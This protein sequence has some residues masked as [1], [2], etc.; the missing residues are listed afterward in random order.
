MAAVE[1]NNG[2]AMRYAEIWKTIKKNG[3]KIPL[4]MPKKAMPM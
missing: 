3:L 4:I 1:P 2:S